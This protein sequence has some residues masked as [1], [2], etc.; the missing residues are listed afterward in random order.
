MAGIKQHQ[1]FH[2]TSVNFLQHQAMNESILYNISR[3]AM[4]R[5]PTYKKMCA[6]LH[7]AAQP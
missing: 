5:T 1:R 2:K 7:K 6:Y 4:G 3:Y